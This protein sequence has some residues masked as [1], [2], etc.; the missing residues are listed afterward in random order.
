MYINSPGG[1]VTS[2]LAIYDTMQYIRCPVGT[3]A[4]GQA[5]SMASLLLSAGEPGHRRTLP[6]SRIMLHQPSGG[7][8]GQAADIEI[9]AREILKMRSTLNGLYRKHTG[10]ELEKIER[11]LDRD[12][13]MDADEAKVFGIVDEVIQQRPKEAG[14]F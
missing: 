12:F 6:H 9:H 10:Q 1:V 4:V 5:A 8:S 14:Q 2:G 7:A 13:F 3:L 11:A